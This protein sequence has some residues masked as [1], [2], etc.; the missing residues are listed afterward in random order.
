MST[1]RL[2]QA[3]VERQADPV[4]LVGGDDA[5]AL[6]RTREQGLVEDRVLVVVLRNDLFVARIRPFYQ[7]RKDGSERRPEANVV[8]PWATSSSS[9]AGKSRRICSSA[10]G[11]IM[12]SCD[13]PLDDGV[14]VA[15]SILARRCPFVATIRICA[16]WSS[17]NTPLRIGRLSSVEAAKAV[18]LISF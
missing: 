8:S 13:A 15:I 10:L 3:G 12:N 11:G 6:E 4:R 5:H 7:S 9:S 2:Q 1:S 18:W 14:F 17:H 16:P